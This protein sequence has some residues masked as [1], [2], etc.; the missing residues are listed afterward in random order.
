MSSASAKSYHVIASRNASLANPFLDKVSDKPSFSLS[1]E[2]GASPRIFYQI[3]SSLSNGFE[4]SSPVQQFIFDFQPPKPVVPEDHAV[5]SKAELSN[6]G[7]G[8]LFTWQKT[9]FTEG[10]VLEIAKDRQFSNKILEKVQK[11]NFFV[12]KAVRPGKYYWRV[13]GYSRGFFSKT[14]EPYEMVIEP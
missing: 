3:K 11:D 2:K 5:M 6:E 8:I 10:Y 1:K 13:K 7:D 12:F 4:V 14:S 9:N